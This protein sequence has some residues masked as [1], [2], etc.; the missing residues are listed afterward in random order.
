MGVR[1]RIRVRSGG[2]ELETPALVSTG[3][4]TEQPEI[5]LPVKLA[6]ELGLYPPES[7]SVI[8]EYSVVGG[9]A[10]LIKSSE[11]VSIRVEVDDRETPSV[12][13]VPV[14]SDRK[15][16]VLISDNLTSRLKISIE[17]PAGGVWRFRD[18]PPGRRRTSESPKYWA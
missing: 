16:E 3:F 9:T 10:I 4:E 8:Q 17:D 7:G 15:S 1:V 5:L 6:E 2:G 12:G 14:I 11:P 13:A 18:D